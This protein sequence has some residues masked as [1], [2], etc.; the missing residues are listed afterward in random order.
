MR[1]KTVVTSHDLTDKKIRIFL[2]AGSCDGLNLSDWLDTAQFT[3]FLVCLTLL[4]ESVTFLT[5]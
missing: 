2:V 4:R 3:A 1:P 5:G